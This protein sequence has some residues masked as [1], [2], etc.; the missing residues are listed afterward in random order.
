MMERPNPARRRFVV[1]GIGIAAVIGV[2]RE[3]QPAPPEPRIAP[4]ALRSEQQSDLDADADVE[5]T[6]VVS[7]LD[8]S[9]EAPSVHAST[10]TRLT[11]GDLLTAWFGGSREGAKDV[12]IYLARW[13]QAEQSWGPAKR[14]IDRGSATRELGREVKKLGNP[15]LHQDPA[16]RIW[17]YVTT[18]SVGGWSGSSVSVKHSDDDGA[19]WSAARRLITT[20]F[21][22]L[23]TLVRNSPIDLADG[24]VLL[25]CYHEFLR[26]YGLIVRLDRDGR[27]ITCYAMNSGTD[28]LQPAIAAESDRDLVAFYRRGGRSDPQILSNRSSDGGSTWTPAEPIALPNPDSS[29]AVL[30]RHGDRGGFLMAFNPDER[31]RDRLALAVAEPGGEWRVVHTFD[32]VSDGK[33]SSYPTLIRGAWDEYHL[34]YSWGRS[35]IAH[36]RFDEAWLERL[37]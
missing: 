6:F 27:L 23:G 28:A 11:G 16:G 24:G 10:I 21:L 34:T 7:F 13:D 8:A 4:I 37:P 19:T 22:N 5:P 25:P 15:V 35:Q 14:W 17:L 33:E 3:L 36:V 31:L 29:V 9:P 32:P 20:P 12:A 30:R 1:I 18:V 26:K 2:W